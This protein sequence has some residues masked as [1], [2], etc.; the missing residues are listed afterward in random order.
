[1]LCV[2]P[3]ILPE[4]RA[5]TTWKREDTVFIIHKSLGVL[6]WWITKVLSEENESRLEPRSAVVVQ[7]LFF[8]LESKLLCEVRAQKERRIVRATL[9]ETTRE[10]KFNTWMTRKHFFP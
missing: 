8:V 10:D 4:L 7:D 1:M 2:S 3:R 9:A 6:F 5:G